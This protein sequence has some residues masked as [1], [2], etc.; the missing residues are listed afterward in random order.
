[1]QFVCKGNVMPNIDSVSRTPDRHQWFIAPLLVVWAVTATAARPVAVVTPLETQN[2]SLGNQAET[3]HAYIE[4]ALV[5]SGTA[6]VVD[7][8]RMDSM[9]QELGFG[10]YSGLADP[11]QAA[12]FGRMLGAHYLVQGTLMDL[13]EELREFSGYGVNT[14][15]TVTSAAV[16]VRVMALET[17]EIV[18][19]R[20]FNGSQTE[21]V[22]S[23]GAQVVG[24]AAGAAVRSALQKLIAD[25]DFQGAFDGFTPPGAQPEIT[26]AVSCTNDPCDLEVNGVYVGSTPTEIALP[27]GNASDIKISK[28]G[29]QAWNKRVQPREGMQINVELAPSMPSD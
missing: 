20:I 22:T 23:S 24:D 7:R 28:A 12:R 5:N 1:M 26:V 27:V 2:Y 16:R 13:R 4:D 21:A 6:S 15:N 17:S 11:A 19:S 18:F 29:F 8:Q 3:A 9:V 14:R 10:N 25:E